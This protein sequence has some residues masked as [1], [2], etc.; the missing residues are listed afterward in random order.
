VKEMADL[1]ESSL[2]DT[3]RFNI[4]RIHVSGDFFNQNYFDAWIHVARRNPEVLF[5]AYTKSLPY[6]IKRLGRIPQNLKL[7]A[8]IGGVHDNMISQYN[9]RSARVVKSIQEAEALGL[10]ID[11][12]DSHAYATDESFALLIH[13]TQRKGSEYG[14]AKNQLRREGIM[15]YHRDK[16]NAA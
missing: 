13:G 7:T 3:R 1:I 5:Y 12:D 4:I 14:L 15:G 2:P 8:S 6:W 11:H 10:P 16:K 9:L